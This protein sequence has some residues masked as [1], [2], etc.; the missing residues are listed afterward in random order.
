MT[1]K[2]III[3]A[4]HREETRVAV[5][6][7]G[8][9]QD[10]DREAVA[11]KQ[12]KGNIYL[13][14]VIRVE[15][16]LQ[17]CFVDYGSDRHGFLPFADIHPDYFQIS[18]S[19]KQRLREITQP[20]KQQ[21]EEEN[22]PQNSNE[23]RN[24]DKGENEESI[25]TG[26]YS[27]EDEADLY[28]GNI[29]S[30]YK[31]YNMQDV[32]KAG[33]MILV[34]VAKEERGNKG[35]SMTSYISIAGKYCVLMAN[36]P[37]K[38]GVSKKVDNFRDRKLLR[39][40]LNEISVPLDRS[41][42]IRT[43]GV[44]KKPEEI[45]RDYDY[46]SRLWDNIRQIANSSTAPNFIHA[47]DDV[48]RRCIRDIYNEQ[49]NEVVVEGATAYETVVNF[50]KLTM[51]NAPQNIKLH[52]ER[53]PVFNKH[54][55]EQQID[56]LY[57]KQIYL[58]SGGS[59]VID[60]AEALVAIDVNSGRATK[61]SGVEETAFSTNLEAVRE[62]ARQLRLRDLAGLIVID[63]IDMYEHRHRRNIERALRD[64][65][66]DDRARI[67][68]GRISVFGLLEMSRQ[69]L[70]ASFFEIITEPCKHCGGTGYVPSVEILAVSILRAIRHACIDKQAGVIYVYANAETIA[71]MLNYKKNDIATTES[72]YGIHIFMHVSDEVGAHGFNIKRR[73]S[74]SDDEKREIEM[75]V[76]TGKVNQL[77]LEKSYFESYE[78]RTSEEPEN[79]NRRDRNKKFRDKSRKNR[80]TDNRDRRKF[81]ERRDGNRATNEGVKKSFLGSLF[82]FGKRN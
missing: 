23:N 76:T 17:A 25:T 39:S 74:L 46:L 70:G 47:E 36:T 71:Y 79:F 69:R 38:G 75:Q 50:V 4:A 18:E 15:P 73:K 10:F 24:N 60:H 41:I 78:N 32:I 30:I 8:I 13:A 26:S 68:L 37:N 66:H 31:R 52:D 6:E 62:I 40:L 12:I 19:E 53:I 49:V 77:G 61:E 21:E 11:I 54:R 22:Q 67:Q 28:R 55:V 80:R 34:Q 5:L 48:I 7:N 14:K 59:I 3:D 35:A 57:E 27:V 33:Q 1:N 16:S 58:P 42:I 81:T 63:F 29:H 45:R 43:A 20:T 9:L 72:S 2:T 65:L 64:E 82:S 51:P 56:A 44:G